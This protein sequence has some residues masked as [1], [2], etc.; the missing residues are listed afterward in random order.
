MQVQPAPEARSGVVVGGASG[1][2]ESRVG[3]DVR[4]RTV[5]GGRRGVVVDGP[6]GVSLPNSPCPDFKGWARSTV[7]F[8]RCASGVLGMFALP[9]HLSK[10]YH[11]TSL[12]RLRRTDLVQRH[13]HE[14][15]FQK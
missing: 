2:I 4:V 5:P 1:K 8:R 9:G 11:G 12:N 15:W 13:D 14:V 6:P 7:A 10:L 3:A